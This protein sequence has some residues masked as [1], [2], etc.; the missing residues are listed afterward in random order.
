MKL[1]T[2]LTTVGLGFALCVEGL[3]HEN[4]LIVIADDVGVDNV[5]VTNEFLTEDYQDPPYPPPNTP[6]L[7]ALAA[8]GVVFRNAWAEPT[9]SPTRAAAITGL[10]PF[11]TGV[12]RSI[13][14][15]IPFVGL[16]PTIPNLANILGSA[17]SLDYATGAFGK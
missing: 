15:S 16:D 3:A 2:T 7:D 12:G 9:C 8:D 11:R 4:F 6:N 13:R 1:G 14:S 17:T 5:N 10:Y